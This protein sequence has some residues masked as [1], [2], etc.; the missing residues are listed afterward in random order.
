MIKK[1]FIFLGY[2]YFTLPSLILA[3]WGADYAGTYAD[4]GAKPPLL[5]GFIIEWYSLSYMFIVFTGII[6]L[7]NKDKD[8]SK[9][10]KSVLV[11][12]S[13]LQLAWLY[14]VFAVLIYPVITL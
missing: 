11:V 6:Y 14:L 13:I 12:A 4:F 2:L 7:I 1:Y 9:W 8:E 3:I 10:L 5:S